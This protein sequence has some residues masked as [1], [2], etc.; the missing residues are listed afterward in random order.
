VAYR[1]FPLGT[2]VSF[3]NSIHPVPSYIKL[4]FLTLFE[5]A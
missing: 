4:N 3:L 2:I 1:Y 5:I